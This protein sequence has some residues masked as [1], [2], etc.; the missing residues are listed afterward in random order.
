MSEWETG[1]AWQHDPQKHDPIGKEPVQTASGIQICEHERV[2]EGWE[3]W[4]RGGY[5]DRD[6][7]HRPQAREDAQEI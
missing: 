7:D 1:I 3:K 5:N 2:P 4:I 6:G